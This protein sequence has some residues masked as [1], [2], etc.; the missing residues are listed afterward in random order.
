MGSSRRNCWSLWS[1]LDD[2]AL[3]VLRKETNIENIYTEQLYTWEE[4]N[5]DPRTRVISSSYIAL[6]DSSSLSIKAGNNEEDARWFN[7]EHNILSEN[8]LDIDNGDSF[9]E[10]VE[11]KLLNNSEKLSAKIR[12]IENIEG[13]IIREIIEAVGLALIMVSL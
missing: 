13:R 1:F 2:A 4:V 10:I 6:V 8:S 5:R 7:I 11:I 12:V 9:E 3:R